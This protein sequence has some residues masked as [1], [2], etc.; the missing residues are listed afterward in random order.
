MKED[1]KEELKDET[2]LTVAKE[3]MT[4]NQELRYY[5]G[6]GDE[7]K[8]RELVTA[9]A[10][11]NV[12][13]EGESFAD[14]NKNTQIQEKVAP[15]LTFDYPLHI[16]AEK[17]QV[18]VISL[19]FFLGAKMENKNR[20]GST[21]LH[22]AVSAGQIEA[23]TEL[24]NLGADARATN[25]MGQTPLHIAVMLNNVEVVK[26]LLTKDSV[27]DLKTVNKVKLIPIEYTM[28]QSPVRKLL[29]QADPSLQEFVQ[30]DDPVDI[31]GDDDEKE[32]KN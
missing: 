12:F 5:V 20:L 2:K 14:V 11:V 21:A 8:I 17:N 28:P 15:K 31:G 27:K 25:N 23:V 19:L 7:E 22:R 26:I 4:P 3:K 16:A 32:N 24:L 6:K 9:G 1:T 29:L 18:K 13:D 10:D 30:Q